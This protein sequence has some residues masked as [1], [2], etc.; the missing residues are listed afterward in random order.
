[1]TRPPT[2][3]VGAEGDG[4][5]LAV[6]AACGRRGMEA[7]LV[8]T[9]EFAALVD[10]RRTDGAVE[11]RPEGAAMMRHE[12]RQDGVEEFVRGER[13]AQLVSFA[14]LSR[15]PVVDQIGCTVPYRGPALTVADLSAPVAARVRPHL[16]PERLVS[17]LA[18]AEGDWDVQDL[19]TYAATRLTPD[20]DRLRPY[21]IRPAGPPGEVRHTTVVAV[22]DRAWVADTAG[23]VAAETIELS[24]AVLG[25]LGVDFG[26]VTWKHDPPL[27]APTIARIDPHPFR[28]ALGDAEEPAADAVA[29]LLDG[30]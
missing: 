23:A 18:D 6:A 11:V 14:G 30:A 10:I 16:V 20:T 17:D 9:A 15:H 2:F 4:V 29:E 8:R 22:R 26:A 28:S 7:R 21:R 5:L 19:N 13:R 27:G 24:V 3:L 12:G 1:V 25:D